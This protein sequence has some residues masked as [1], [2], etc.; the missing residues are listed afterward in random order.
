MF[1]NHCATKQHFDEVGLSP[2]PRGVEEYEINDNESE[3]EYLEG[4]HK[5]KDKG[6]DNDADDE[7]IPATRAFI[8]HLKDPPSFIGDLD[9]DAMGAL[10]FPEY[11]NMVGGCVVGSELCIGMEFND[12][13]DVV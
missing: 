11:V 9:L 3:D 5:S 8:Q 13:G 7:D 4:H 2:F 6:A 10:K 12:R 1:T